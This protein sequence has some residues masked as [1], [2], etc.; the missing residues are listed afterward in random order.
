MNKSLL[1]VDDDLPFRERLSRS[2]QKK[3]FEVDIVFEKKQKS[4]YYTS[5]S[6]TWLCMVI[7]LKR[8]S[9][10][11]TSSIFEQRTITKKHVAVVAGWIIPWK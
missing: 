11:L 1:V 3:G 8:D 2:M 9:L 4:I 6:S 7:A 5:I 10:K